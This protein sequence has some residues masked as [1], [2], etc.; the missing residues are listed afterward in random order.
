MTAEGLKGF[1]QEPIRGKSQL[2]LHKTSSLGSNVV[3]VVLPVDDTD[4]KFRSTDPA[5][6][7]VTGQKTGIHLR[8]ASPG[9]SH[10]GAVVQKGYNL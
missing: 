2:N 1:Q 4:G 8:Q 10:G 5:L 6:C 9:F 7:R 3:Q